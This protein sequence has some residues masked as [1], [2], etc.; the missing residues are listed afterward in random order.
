MIKTV[1]I[2]PAEQEFIKRVAILCDKEFADDNYMAKILHMI[3]III[4]SSAVS[5][6]NID[7]AWTKYQSDLCCDPTLIQVIKVDQEKYGEY[8]VEVRNS[9]IV[10]SS[11]LLIA[12]V[13]PSSYEH[14]TI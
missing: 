9:I 4:A 8:A 3:N 14:S 6:T 13:I 12:F 10:E 2:Y 5:N 1:E 11:D 7:N